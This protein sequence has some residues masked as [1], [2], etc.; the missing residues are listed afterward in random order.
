MRKPDTVKRKARRRLLRD[1]KL[2]VAGR[3]GNRAE[4]R[5]YKARLHAL[6]DAEWDLEAWSG[7]R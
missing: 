7:G 4:L 5:A 3:Q 6:E 1:R 2:A